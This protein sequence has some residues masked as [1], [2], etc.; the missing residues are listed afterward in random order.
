MLKRKPTLYWWAGAVNAIFAGLSASQGQWDWAIFFVVM[1]LVF[2]MLD[3]WE[4]N[5]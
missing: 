4:K 3:S 1:L 2:A 5:K